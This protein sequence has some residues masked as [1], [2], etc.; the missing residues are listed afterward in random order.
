[1]KTPK[2]FARQQRVIDYPECGE[3]VWGLKDNLGG[4]IPMPK[5][6]A[7]QEAEERNTEIAERMRNASLSHL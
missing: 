5:E 4:F 1:M 2:Y 6:Q 7:E 3:T